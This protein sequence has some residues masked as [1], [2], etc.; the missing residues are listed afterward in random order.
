MPTGPV[1][2]STGIEAQAD[3]EEPGAEVGTMAVTPVPVPAPTEVQAGMVAAME[4]IAATRV[5]GTALGKGTKN[6]RAPGKVSFTVY[7]CICC[8]FF[9]NC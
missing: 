7:L 4:P 9:L 1:V 8:L 3:T 6:P 5:P 2:P